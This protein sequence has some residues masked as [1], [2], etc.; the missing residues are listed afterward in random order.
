MTEPSGLMFF[1]GRAPFWLLKQ[2]LGVMAA[3]VAVIHLF[4]VV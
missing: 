1:H 2:S 4:V 3:L